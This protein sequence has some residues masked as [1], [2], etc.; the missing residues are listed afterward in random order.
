MIKRECLSKKSLKI[1][2]GL[3]ELVNRSFPHSWLITGFVVRSTRRLSLVEQDLL[4]LPG[5]LSSPRVFIGSCFSIFSFICTFCRSLF[6]LLYFFFWPLYRLFFFDLRV[7]IT[8]TNPVISHEWGKDREV[9]T[10]SRTYPWSFVT[11]IFHSDQPSHS[12]DRKTS[13]VMTST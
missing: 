10:T 1:P 4:T 9:F 11:Q 12:G 5:H 6:V 7:L 13:K 3:S 8:P 2:K